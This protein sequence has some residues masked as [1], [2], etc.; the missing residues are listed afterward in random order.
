MTSTEY[1]SNNETT[2]I[3]Y[4][5]S[6]S[7][8]FDYKTKLVGKL[9]DGE[10]EL[11]NVKIVVSLK[12]LSRFVFDLDFLMINSEIELI[13]K[14]TQDC[15]LTEKS[16][17]EAKARQDGPPVLDSVNAVNIPYGL[18]FNTSDCKL[19]VP[20]VTLQTEY[21]NQLYEELKTG[22]SIDFTGPKYRSQAINQTE[23][24]I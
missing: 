23:L 21:Q 8:S 22:I 14:W 18:K 5:I 13:L 19:Y 4:P 6:N 24:T 9:L 15:V 11:E 3:F 1:V 12:N 17:R 2:R 20:V 16:T 10:N 7:K